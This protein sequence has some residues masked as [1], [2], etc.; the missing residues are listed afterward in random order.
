MPQ[1]QKHLTAPLLSLI[2]VD[3]FPDFHGEKHQRIKD[4]GI[5]VE[6]EDVQ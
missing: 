3:P 2:S 4:G 5:G 6:K 1:V